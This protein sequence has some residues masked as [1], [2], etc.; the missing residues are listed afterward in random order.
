M[1]S[2]DAVHRI[3]DKLNEAFTDEDP[4]DVL[5]AVLR[6]LSYILRE[7]SPQERAVYV[8]RCFGIM[9]DAN[10]RMSVERRNLQ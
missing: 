2:Q 4:D 9:D 5:S 6:L 1:G 7:F 10:K 3:C 8:N